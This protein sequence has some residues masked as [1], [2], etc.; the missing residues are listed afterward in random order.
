MAQPQYRSHPARGTI[1]PLCPFIKAQPNTKIKVAGMNTYTYSS[2]HLIWL[3]LFRTHG[4]LSDAGLIKS[5]TCYQLRAS[6][7]VSPQKPHRKVGQ[8][9]QRGEVDPNRAWLGPT[10]MHPRQRHDQTAHP[11]VFWGAGHA[12]GQG[13][14]STLQTSTVPCRHCVFVLIP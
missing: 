2:V 12:A 3:V 13:S 11:T 10:V 14:L 5:G 1:R 8:P 4:Q 7:P 9:T 6:F